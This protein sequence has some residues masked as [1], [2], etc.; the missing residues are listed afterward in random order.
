MQ[1]EKFYSP[2]ERRRRRWPRLT[3]PRLH[4]LTAGLTIAELALLSGVSSRVISEVERSL[5]AYT[6]RER[7]AVKEALDQ[8]ASA[9]SAG[10]VRAPS[11]PLAAHMPRVGRAIK[12][13][14]GENVVGVFPAGGGAEPLI[15]DI[16]HS[17]DCPRA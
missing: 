16:K 10:S 7:R 17:A 1:P 13:T 6:E 8:V 9:E 11:P 15:A 12:L 4:R 3:A 5:R 14:V 2:V